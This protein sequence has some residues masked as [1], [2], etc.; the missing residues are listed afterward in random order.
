MT[1]FF[2]LDDGLG[3]YEE[4]LQLHDEGITQIPRIGEKISITEYETDRDNT[5]DKEIVSYKV[6]DVCH[7]LFCNK[8]YSSNWNQFIYVFLSK[9]K[10]IYIC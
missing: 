8:K 2:M 3:S 6:K 4:L 5:H 1:C 7:E 9:I 10:N